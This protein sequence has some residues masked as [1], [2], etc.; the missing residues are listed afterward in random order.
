MTT[1]NFESVAVYAEL[2]GALRLA[3][4]ARAFVTDPT[5]GAPVDATQGAVVAPYVDADAAGDVTFT[6]ES[7]PVRLTNGA[8]YEDVWPVDAAG[9][10]GTLTDAFVAAKVA[11]TSPSLTRAALAARFAKLSHVVVG[12]SGD[13]ATL[14]EVFTDYPTGYVNIELVSGDHTLASPISASAITNVIIRGQGLGST[15]LTSTAGFINAS[16]ACNEWAIRDLSIIHAA[17]TNTDDGI[18]VDYPRRWSVER[19]SIEGFGGTSVW[20]KGGIHSRIEFNRIAA[21]DSTNTNGYAGIYIS[22]SDGDIYATTICTTSNYIVTGKGYGVLAKNAA[23]SIFSGD[24]VEYCAVG[25]RFEQCTGELHTPYTESNYG[26]AIELF[27]SPLPCIGTFR[28]EPIVTWLSVTFADRYV[29]RVSRN[30][31]NPGKALIYGGSAA[32]ADATTSPSIRWGA[33]SPE[34]AQTAVVGSTWHRTDGGTDTTEYRKEAGTGNTGWVASESLNRI[35]LTAGSCWGNTGAPAL[36][37]LGAGG[38]ARIPAWVLDAAAYEAVSGLVS[39][40]T[41]WTTFNVDMWWSNV[42]AGAGDVMF[43]IDRGTITDGAAVPAVTS[44][45]LAAIAAPAQK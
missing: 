5:T 28:T 8:T 1:Y 32:G 34:G 35:D 20:Y 30:W 33:G 21:K 15:T 2:G 6:A 36:S 26:N 24:I 14:A 3:R 29:T 22:K 39:I 44:V 23:M 10:A 25:M 37:F 4:G 19:C 12:P 27:D 9:P 16:N 43:R 40:P 11:D 18:V 31:V 7:W 45:S 17:G 38:T 41:S 13:Y 42:G